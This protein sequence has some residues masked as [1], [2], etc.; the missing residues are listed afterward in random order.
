MK[1][2][3]QNGLDNIQNKYHNI[4]IILNG[5]KKGLCTRIPIGYYVHIYSWISNGND[6]FSKKKFVQVSLDWCTN[7][8]P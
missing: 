3:I 8:Q 7:K 1:H 5:F 4:K 6:H 2:W